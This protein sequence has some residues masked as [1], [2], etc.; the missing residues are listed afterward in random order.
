MDF[1]TVL[2]VAFG[3]SIATYFFPTPLEMT[4]HFKSAQDFYAS[5]DYK[6]AVEQYD[7]ILNTESILLQADS[8]R[9]SLLNNEINVG[10]RTAAYYQKANALRN[11][12]KK[13]ESIEFL[14]IVEKR[15]DSPKLAALAQ[16]QIYEMYYGDKDYPRAI[17][18]A[19][20]LI[21]DHPLD[22]KI[23]RAWF[24]IGWSFRELGMI[25]SSNVAFGT[26]VKDFSQSDLD[27][28]AR[29]QIAQNYFDQKQWDKSIQTF[30]DLIGKY[31]PESFAS[32]EWENVELKAVRDRKLFEA[33][34][35]READATTLELTAKA[36]VK[37]GDCYR[38]LGSYPQAMQNYQSVIA[39]F[40]L[41]PT[42]VE[43]TYNKMAEYTAELKGTDEGI[44][45]YRDAIDQNF[46]NKTLQAK[47]QYKIARTLQD[48]KQY[49]RAA[50][51]YTFYVDA[52]APQAADIK[53]PVEQALFL[54]VS[55]YYNARNFQ[56]TISSVDTMLRRFPQTEY[57]A[58]LYMYDG[59]SFAGLNR[60]ADARAYYQR[61]IQVAPGSNEAI[62]AQTQIGKS[63]FDEKNYREAIANFETLLAGD[64]S[65]LDLSEIHYLLG[66]SYYG[67]S[68]YDKAINH[69]RTVEPSSSY[70]PF[71][72]ARI[73]RAYTSRQQFDEADNY[74]DRAFAEAR[75]D[76][77]DF[78]AFV[79]L[80]RSELYTSQQRYDQAIAQFD[81]VAYDSSQT[82]N[83]RAQARYGR[84]L[85]Y[86]ELGKFKESA[87][88]LEFCLKSEVFLQVFPA[89]VPQ[90][91]EKLSFCYAN[92]GRKKEGLQLITELAASAATELEQSRY[93]AGICE[94]HY[95]AGDF[96]KSVETGKQLLVLKTKDETA[97]IRTYVTMA[98]SY[99]NLQQHAK[100][101]EVLTEAG[102]KFPTNSYIEETFYQ[103]GMIYFSGG[104]HK[105]AAEAFGNFL[106]KF[107][108]SKNYE[109]AFYHRGVSL[110]ESGQ[111]E[112][113]IKS[114]REFIKTFP[115]SD[116]CPEAQ[117]QIGEAYFNTNRF[118]EAA[119]EYQVV[120][121]LYPSNENASLA[122]FNEGWC[123]YQ[124]T[125]IDNMFS[126]FRQLVTRYPKSKHAADAQ[127][128]IGDYYYNQKTYDSALLAYQTF[129]Q[130]FSQDPRIEEAKSLIKDLSQV[131]AYK[132][133]EAAM[134]FFE[135][136]NWSQ[137]VQ[138]LTR[139]MD[140]YPTTD[141]VY[142][143][144]ANIAS[145]YE[146]LGENKKAMTVFDE[147]IRD[148]KDLEIARPAVFF[149][150]LHKRWIEAG[151]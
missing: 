135:A 146:Q 119:R 75:K 59:L 67:I 53:F 120:Y 80:A 40:A 20:H 35:S 91:K 145:C 72:F 115:Q 7:I 14:R 96:A 12:G 127:F 81:T 128:T 140:K 78:T 1:K 33:Q 108:K 39:T 99:G 44:Q 139:V 138:E 143:C 54:T 48:A 123:Y 37:I 150:E 32:A 6:R 25:D 111:A 102:Q 110:Y 28:K 79:R 121:R 17:V 29:Y 34:Q 13:E 61:V 8:V 58:K 51:E 130:L 70:Y 86:F 116:L 11:L 151:K 36:Q 100:A 68:E 23:P 21:T 93:L 85:V 26:I 77:L 19:R 10:V 46:S 105:S 137:A 114:L 124:S 122:L 131:E 41:M 65:K 98:N 43:V 133:Y 18:E 69:L 103:L 144:K 142:G 107:P 76:S 60:Q 47:L 5:R 90:A 71:T 134:A 101:I 112:E 55:N 132:E 118:A 42:L 113:S 95:R 129:L 106:Q 56:K 147:I 94:F 125:Q 64:T 88:D 117:I 24:D 92:T 82:Q 136:K 109:D 149:A 84:G 9:V 3:F 62:L 50:S 104:D 49:E 148:W 97:E 89:L 141:V 27:P 30:Q 16:Y 126:V 63:H 66:L 45:V 15:E 22:E 52:Y 74:L 38:N 31:R 73:T 2:I 87:S 57:L 4:T 83:T